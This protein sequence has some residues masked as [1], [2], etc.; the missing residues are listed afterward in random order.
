MHRDKPSRF[1]T[2]IEKQR[3]T[4][5]L[6][7]PVAMGAGIVSYFNGVGDI[8]F[9]TYVASGFFLILA[10][11][12]SVQSYA[13][14]GRNMWL[15][16]MLLSIAMSL[17]V[18]G[19]GAAQYRTYSLQTPLLDRD[20]PPAVIEGTIEKLVVLDGGTAKRVILD[21]VSTHDHDDVTIDRVR[22]KTYHFKGDDWQN[23]DRVQV[24]AKLLPPSGPVI[25]D[26]FDFRFKAYYDG[27]SAVGYTMGDAQKVAFSNAKTDHVQHFRDS[28]GSRLYDVMDPRYAGIAQALLTGERSGISD[29]DTES[30][31]AS[32]LAHLLAIS[33]L[34][35]GL[36]AGCV[37]FF[38]RYGLV[39][40]PGLALR[41]PIKKY[42]AICAIIIAF[43]YM[44]LAGATVPTVRAFIMTSLVLLAIILDRSALN[45]RLVAF[46]AM[47][48]M[49]I[50]PEAV[51]GPSFVLS[52]AAV[53]G[54]IAFYQGAGRQWLMN[55]R[56]HQPLWRPVYY[57]AGIIAT[58]VVATL[59]TAPFSVMFFNRFAVYS[60]IANVGA[61]PLMAFLVMPF[62]LI[63]TLLIPF[64][65]DHY[66]WWVME[67]GLINIVNIATQVASYDQ[68]NLYLPSF[69]Y[70]GM[71]LICVGF[72]WLILWQGYWRWIGVLSIIIAFIIPHYDVPP[73]IL[74][75]DKMETILIVDKNVDN[76]YKI[77]RMNRY[78]KSNWLGFLG[79]SPAVD[80]P[81]WEG[82]DKSK[83]GHYKCDD[84]ACFLTKN[85]QKI[86]IALNPI[87]MGSVCQNSD[88][89]IAKIPIEDDLCREKMIIDRF[90]IWRN[91]PTLLI[92]GREH[93][94]VKTVRG[95]ESQ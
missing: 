87:S 38:V 73:R 77:G 12:K 70:F 92:V 36:V 86:G 43:G 90:D 21:D 42:A 65:L 45:M 69:G 8:P 51:L 33:G 54:L 59:A 76:L 57:V 95:D 32:G 74:I 34:H 94:T 4:L 2:H 14:T 6:W 83:S 1:I 55:A 93:Y 68:A 31:R 85:D 60:V 48:V 62:G 47:I 35:I 61:M 23:G 71:T 41:R 30:L 9:E 46:A 53:A 26:G 52:F 10:L 82:G 39:L 67:W 78:T 5:F 40:V 56:S 15:I 27:L 19:H 89:V 24:R 84:M 75:S 28:I 25:P 37:F 79:V 7:S 18:V 80:I 44:V 11:S 3:K 63:S 64:N 16:A 17:F 72:L 58:T 13:K 81:S 22:L 88:F 49:I 66:V 20:I 29:D 50:T 91:G